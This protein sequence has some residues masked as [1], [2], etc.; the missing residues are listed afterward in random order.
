M[1]E[2]K[3]NVVESHGQWR[4]LKLVDFCYRHVFESRRE[5]VTEHASEAALERREF[6][7]RF[8]VERC[9]CLRHFGKGSRRVPP[10]DW[11]GGNE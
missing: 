8:F 7:A 2:G 3:D 4:Q 11:V 10:A 1:I 6:G 5:F 9:G